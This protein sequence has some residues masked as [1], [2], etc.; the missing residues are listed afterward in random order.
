VSKTSKFRQ[1]PPQHNLPPWRAMHKSAGD[2]R[3]PWPSPWGKLMPNCTNTPLSPAANDICCM[4]AFLSWLFAL[5]CHWAAGMPQADLM[6]F[7]HRHA[8]LSR[9]LHTAAWS[10]TQPAHLTLGFDITRPP[11]RGPQQAL[12]CHGQLFFNHLLL[13][14]KATAHPPLGLTGAAAAAA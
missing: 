13:C 6:C 5:T 8:L 14:R 11:S 10:A 9:Q 12:L 2:L 7:Q 4:C 1:A 3:R